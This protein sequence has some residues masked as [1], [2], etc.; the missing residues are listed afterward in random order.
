MSAMPPWVHALSDWLKSGWT[1]VALLATIGGGALGWERFRGQ[2]LTNKKLRLEN[3]KLELEV[4]AMSL[5]LR[6]EE[7]EKV[8]QHIT[9]KSLPETTDPPAAFR[10]LLEEWAKGKAVAEV[11]AQLDEL[12]DRLAA[13]EEALTEFS[14]PY[15]GAPLSE[16]QSIPLDDSQDDWGTA[17]SYDC[18]YTTSDLG[19]T[20]P[21]PAD[22]DF[23]KFE[24]FEMLT[25]QQKDGQWSCWP[26]PLTAHAHRLELRGGHGRTE[27]EAIGRI[28]HEYELYAT[29]QPWRRVR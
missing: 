16:R 19:V 9:G 6:K 14:C 12:K 29:Q 21:C 13:S 27:Q 28:R 11:N 22:P 5:A 26:K 23:P 10:G 2:R 20:R 18:G 8:A 15:C 7:I 25:S 24:E 3:Q 4:K 17:E 1:P